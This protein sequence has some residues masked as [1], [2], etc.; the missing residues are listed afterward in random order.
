MTTKLK[1]RHA[2][3]TKAYKAWVASMERLGY[4]VDATQ[5]AYKEEGGELIEV[6]SYNQHKAGQR[7][8]PGVLGS[9]FSVPKPIETKTSLDKFRTDELDYKG[10]LVPKGEIK[11]LPSSFAKKFTPV[12]L[13]KELG[14]TK[15]T[16]PAGDT[17]GTGMP[18]NYPGGHRGGGKVTDDFTDKTTSTA[19]PTTTTKPSSSRELRIKNFKPSSI[20]KKLI[21]S[22]FTPTELVDLQIKHEDW[23]KNRGR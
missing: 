2:K 13:Q 10:R 22:G 17:Y 16:K 9:K 20:Q 1:K 18:S 21:N 6:Q 8:S 15:E 19:K 11:S 7:L 14:A 5:T 23:Q 4:K 3:Q 12:E